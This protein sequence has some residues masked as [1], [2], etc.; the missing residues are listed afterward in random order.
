MNFKTIDFN[1]LEYI[2]S[3]VIGLATLNKLNKNYFLKCIA[4]KYK[5][6]MLFINNNVSIFY[7]L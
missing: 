6:R 2:D 4:G 3:P 7:R 5:N 1:N